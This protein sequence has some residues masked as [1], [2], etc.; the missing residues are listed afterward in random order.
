MS[1]VEEGLHVPQAKKEQQCH[2]KEDEDEGED[3]VGEWRRRKLA[4]KCL[5]YL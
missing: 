3:D 5:H 1:R 2:Q 4:W